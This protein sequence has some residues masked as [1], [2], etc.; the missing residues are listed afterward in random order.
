M[1]E[2]PILTKEKRFPGC[3]FDFLKE[4]LVGSKSSAGFAIS[5]SFVFHGGGFPFTRVFPCASEWAA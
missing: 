4:D 2:K 1:D 3:S 5:K